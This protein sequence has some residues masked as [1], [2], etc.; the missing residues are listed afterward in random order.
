MNYSG[1]AKQMVCKAA[2][3]LALALIA[4]SEDSKS[5]ADGGTAEERGLQANNNSDA[6]HNRYTVSGRAV[7]TG[8]TGA[9]S[10][11]TFQGSTSLD[12]LSLQGSFIP[13]GSVLRLSELD[14]LT[15]DATGKFYFT[16]CTN[17]TGQFSFD[18]VSL[19]SPYVLVEL[20]PEIYDDS[21][22]ELVNKDDL[23]D[24]SDTIHY[25]LMGPLNHNYSALVDLRTTDDIAV[26]IM[27]RLEAA[28]IKHLFK[29]GTAFATAKQQA[30]QEILE[31]VGV[32]NGTFNF[33]KS[34]FVQDSNKV[35]MAYRVERFIYIYTYSGVDLNNYS[36]HMYSTAPDYSASAV[37][38]FSKSGNFTAVDSVKAA[39]LKNLLRW[40][41]NDVDY[42][43][44]SEKAFVTGFLAA[45]YSL[46][47][48]TAAREGDTVETDGYEDQYLNFTCLSGAWTAEPGRYKIT[49]KVNFETGTMTDDRDGKTYKTVTYNIEGTPFTWMAE[50]LT[51]SNDSI[52]PAIGLDSSIYKIGQGGRDRDFIKHMNS[53]DST[54]WNSFAR[55]AD[56]DV[57]GADSIVM[58]GEHFQGICPSGWH[59][60][61]HEEWTRLMR[62]VEYASGFCPDYPGCE[63]FKANDGFGWDG[64][65]YLNHIGFGDFTLEIFAFLEQGDDGTWTLLGLIMDNW[66][67]YIMSAEQIPET[68]S[69]RCVK[70]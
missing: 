58:E 48:C 27:T 39:L 22:W 56:H 54:Y 26:N 10:S 33:D 18:S 20:L 23:K 35:L 59:I 6:A 2:V 41:L 15:L 52:H 62:L 66:K 12:S 9:S 43:S 51:Y 3:L 60:P 65:E 21:E 57:I 69:I 30:D 46:G 14:S 49:E 45:L 1:I 55:Y 44:N 29:N 17:K 24:F 19:S 16:R 67:P 40:S 61:T 38:A 5:I 4:C 34:D 64:S 28:R 11:D 42:A 37:N 68:L 47:E 31:A 7:G 25:S 13:Y 70:D 8:G 63:E 36:V 53:L 50:N 32:Y